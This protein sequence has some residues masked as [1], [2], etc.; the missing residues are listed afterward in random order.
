[1]FARLHE[2]GIRTVGAWICGWDF[3][4]H[5]NMHEDLNYFVACYPTFQQLTRMSPFPGTVMYDKLNEEGR[6]RNVPWDDVHFWSGAQVNI[7][8]ETHE[9]LNLTEYG[10]K[11]L[12]D[13]WGPSLLRRLDVLLNGYE[14]C[15]KSENQN[16]REHTAT[17]FRN[18]A[19]L[20]MC[21]S[22]AMYHFAPN[23]VVRRRV[24]KLK[25]RFYNV[26]I[27]E[28]TPVM[29]LADWYTHWQA[30]KWKKKDLLDP[31]NQYPKQEP[32]KRYIYD[33]KG[34]KGDIPYRTE[35]PHIKGFRLRFEM[36]REVAMWKVLSVACVVKKYMF[37]WKGD[38]TID[39]YIIQTTRYRTFYG[40]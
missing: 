38:K 7:N 32:Y 19:A 31:F 39:N 35:Y 17:L 15:L 8:L 2:R 24:E 10:Y 25:E 11:L 13:T 30:K 29:K 20:T 33:K 37:F 23:G 4:T 36:L 21:I 3:H 5:Q 22:S 28:M 26:V 40:F 6:V 14:Y 16:M 27:P 1:V 18:Q 9:T 34:G 12:T